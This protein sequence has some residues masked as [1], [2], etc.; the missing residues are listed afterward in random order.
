MTFHRSQMFHLV[1]GEERKER[2]DIDTGRF[3]NSVEVDRNPV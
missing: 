2:M 3:V 1:T